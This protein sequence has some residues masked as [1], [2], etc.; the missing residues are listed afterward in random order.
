MHIKDYNSLI[1]LIYCF[2]VLVNKNK[3]SHAPFTSL[4]VVH[5]TEFE[6]FYHF[7]GASN[8]PIFFP[9]HHVPKYGGHNIK[10]CK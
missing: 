2:N 10:L 3:P 7:Y 6:A 1:T 8:R 9:H 4:I 5:A